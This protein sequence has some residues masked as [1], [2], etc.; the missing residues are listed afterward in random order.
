MTSVLDPNAQY[1]IS[2]SVPRRAK[3][4]ALRRIEWRI[5]FALSTPKAGAELLDRFELSADRCDA[6]L[7][8][9]MDMGLV[10]LH[11]LAPPAPAP[12]AVPPPPP[13]AMPV[14]MPAPVLP[15]P[16]PPAAVPV[17]PPAPRVPAPP[18]FTLPPPPPRMASPMPMPPPLPAEALA[19]PAPPVSMNG[20]KLKPIIDFIQ[21]AS[22]SGTLGQLTVYR[23]FLKIPP[24][25]LKEAR[26]QSVKFVDDNFRI[27]SKE[28]QRAI[29][30]A[31]KKTLKLD[32][33]QDLLP[34]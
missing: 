16:P 11:V 23:V 21:S 15:P 4:L 9:L 31:V 5:L 20:V 19:P 17:P 18:S 7:K 28:L 29:R 2:G 30:D 10:E 24:N 22:G 25:L 3:E 33:P 27:E 12:V 13:L 26:I 34:A 6:V 32:V 8:N 14:P 1:L